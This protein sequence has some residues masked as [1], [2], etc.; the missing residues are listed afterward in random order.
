MPDTTAQPLTDCPA[1]RTELAIIA[2]AALCSAALSLHAGSHL[3]RRALAL[4]AQGRPL[5]P[6]S[7]VPALG[8]IDAGLLLATLALVAVLIGLEWRRAAL[9]RFLRTASRGQMLLLVAVLVA[10]LGHSFLFP[11]LLVAAD[12]GSHIVRFFEVGLALRHGVVPQW[13][14]YQYLGSPLLAFTGPLTYLTGGAIDALVGNAVLAAKLLLFG[15]HLATGLLFYAFLRRLSLS[16]PAAAVGAVGWTGSFGYL[17]L[18]LYRGLYPQALTILLMVV[19]FHAAEGLMRTRQLRPWDW[20]WFALGTGGLIVNHQPHAPFV[21]LYL[22]IWGGVSLALGRWQWR[23]L[24]WLAS[25]GSVGVLIAMVALL[26]VL[27]GADWVMMDP[28]SG[29]FRLHAPTAERLLRLVLWRDTRSNWGPDYWAY[30]GLVS[31]LL[32]AYGA[33]AG[34]RRLPAARPLVLGALPCLALGLFLWNPVVRDIMFLGFFLGIMTAVGCAAL[35]AR[36]AL[37]ALTLVFLD[38]ASTAI[39]PIA[40]PDKQFQ[41]DAG[42]YLQQVAPT[43]RVV[44]VEFTYD[45][46]WHAA[47]GPEGRLDSYAAAL[48]RVSG[49]HNMAATRVHNYATVIVNRAERELRASGRVTAAT[50]DLLAVLNVHRIVCFRPF[51]MGCPAGFRDATAE[52]PLGPVVPIPDASPVLFSPRLV[53]LLPPHG[54]DKPALWDPIFA[55]EPMPPRLR[56]IS[57]FLDAW[58]AQARPDPATRIAQALPVRDPPAQPPA[59]DSGDWHPRLMH[60][61]LTLQ[62]VSLT[63]AADRAGF[64]QLA[65]P[66]YPGTEV[67]VNGQVVQP[68]RGAFNLI[69]LPIGPGETVITLRPRITPATRLALALSGGGLLLALGGTV[70]LFGLRARRRPRPA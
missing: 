23:S 65:H 33:W 60:Y 69:V 32:G 15:T 58:L 11:G 38:T 12:S 24:A 13:T 34:L 21:A 1:P 53:P 42:R 16:R 49:Y 7:L 39:L 57:A 2:A 45:G 70:A 47:T 68:M 43:D 52:G 62:T 3:V 8:W 30:L 27:E 25:A 17:Q 54:M 64:V 63:V 56:A 37:L 20:L 31:V 6:R 67:R 50:A 10:W 66:W 35:P 14:N 40:R 36:G 48:P 5:A 46:T 61:A 22:A 55:M 18:F 44:E 26:P 41:V 4:L 19:V 29:F 28:D 51:A 59:A 9:S